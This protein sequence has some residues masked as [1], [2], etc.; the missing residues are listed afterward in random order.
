MPIPPLAL[1]AG[2][3]G[4]SSAGSS[5]IQ[6]SGSRRSQNRAN[7]HNINFWKMQNEYNHPSAQMERLRKAGLNPNLVYGGSPSQTAGNAGAISPSKAAPFNFDN[8]LSTINSFVDAQKSEAQTDN[9]KANTTV[10]EQEAIL[11]AYRTA[12]EAARGS[13]TKVDAEL[14]QELKD[15]SL[16]AAKENLRQMEA[17]TIQVQLDNEI[18]DASKKNLIKDV[19]YRVE[20]AKE[21]LRG[22]QLLNTLRKLE[23]ELKSIGIEKNDPWYFRIFGRNID[24]INA[25]MQSQKKIKK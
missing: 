18:K 14:A 21:N 1:A 5:L 7:R 22:Q 17:K 13:K 3:S 9:V 10:Q 6:N 12:T 20:N 15:T 16:Q 2:I 19:F 24:E 8:P 23:A 25:L 11:R 4:V